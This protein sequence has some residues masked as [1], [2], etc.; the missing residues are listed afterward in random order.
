[1]DD[2]SII[3]TKSQE[4]LFLTAL[5]FV[6]ST[7]PRFVSVTFDNF[8]ISLRVVPGLKFKCIE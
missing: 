7:Q 5:L 4:Q 1:M 6:L 8:K 2:V 3:A